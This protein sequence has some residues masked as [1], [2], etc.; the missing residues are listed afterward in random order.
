MDDN[1]EITLSLRGDSVPA[2]WVAH[3]TNVSDYPT[4]SRVDVPVAT[5]TSRRDLMV[6]KA[7]LEYSLEE[8]NAK[9]A[10]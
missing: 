10:G 3:Q 9:L 8:I 4:L 5:G 6:M 1:H 7:L 2:V